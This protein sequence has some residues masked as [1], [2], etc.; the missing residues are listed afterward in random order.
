MHFANPETVFG[1]SLEQFSFMLA[2]LVLLGFF[3]TGVLAHSH[4]LEIG[5]AGAVLAYLTFYAWQLELIILIIGLAVIGI[6]RWINGPPEDRI[7]LPS[8]P[9]RKE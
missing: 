7:R 9:D 1:L 3:L 4:N 8:Q 6:A 5:G 2:T